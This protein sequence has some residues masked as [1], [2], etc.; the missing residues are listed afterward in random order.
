MCCSMRIKVVVWLPLSFVL[1]SWA[2]SLA[3]GDDKAAPEFH[4]EA[5]RHRRR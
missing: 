3:A 4:E 1:V 5:D 2:A